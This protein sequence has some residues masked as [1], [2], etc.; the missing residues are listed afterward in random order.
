MRRISRTMKNDPGLVH[1]GTL[2]HRLTFLERVITV[3]S[4]ITSEEWKPAFT[5]MGRIETMNG[6]EFF[7]A[8]AIN[9]ENDVRFV[10]RYRPGVT[11]EMRVSF[12]GEVYEITA[13]HNP[14][15]RNVKL[16]IMATL[17]NGGG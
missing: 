6:R 16:E 14:G 3:K 17:Y 13:V 10:I 12:G 5:P 15:M 2:R 1:S 4:G 9:R 7:Q 8:A 11:A